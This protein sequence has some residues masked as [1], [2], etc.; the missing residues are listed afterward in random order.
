MSYTA[1]VIQLDGRTRIKVCAGEY[2]VGYFARM[3]DV[4]DHGLPI[5]PADITIKE[6]HEDRGGDRAGEGIRPEAGR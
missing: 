3:E 6:R 1:E 2:L 4:H 5:D